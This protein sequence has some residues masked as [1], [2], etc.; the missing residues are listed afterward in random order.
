MTLLIDPP[1]AT[2]WVKF[3]VTVIL[4]TVC[5]AFELLLW[6]CFWLDE[7]FAEL[8]TLEEMPGCT[9]A[10]DVGCTLA[11]DVPGRSVAE[12]SPG[13]TL[14][15]ESGSGVVVAFA[16]EV[17]VLVV[18]E[19]AGILVLLALTCSSVVISSKLTSM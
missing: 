4:P 3:P 15:E 8:F 17:R 12:E 7:E 1:L 11:E 19:D 2:V 14:A 5:C 6:L 10:E 16:E 13:S 9:S 18:A